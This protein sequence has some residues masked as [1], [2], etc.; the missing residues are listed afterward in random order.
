MRRKNFRSS[1]CLALIAMGLMGVG[2]FAQEDSGGQTPADR[3]ATLF[4]QDK[5]QGQA[6]GK[7]RGRQDKDFAPD[8]E[9]F[10]FLLANHDKIRREVK[11]LDNGVETLTESDDAEISKKIQEHVAAMYKRVETPNPIHLRDPLFAALFRQTDKIEMKVE[12][13]E[14]GVRVVETSEDAQTVRLIQA[15]AR[16]VSLFVK[17]GAEEVRKNHEVPQQE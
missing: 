2:L 14:R 16:V 12:K 3:L 7:G 11:Q 5:G 10:H 13:T 17:H 1:S 8:R 9:V 6:Q 4:T 15:H